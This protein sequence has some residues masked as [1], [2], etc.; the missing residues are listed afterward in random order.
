MASTA[1]THDDHAGGH[2]H[3]KPNHPY[4]LVDPS[5]WPLVGSLSALLLTGGGV[6][7]MHGV[8][9]G[10][11]VTLLGFAGV[12]AV[13]V[14]WW[15]DVLRELAS[16]AHSDVVSKG[17]RLGMALFIVSEVFFF[18][19]FFWA[20]FWGALNP[21]MTVATQWP[22]EGVEPVPAWGIPFLNTLILLLSGAAVTWAHHAVRENDQQGPR[23][24]PLLITVGLGVVFTGFQVLEYVEQIHAGFTL[25]GARSGRSAPPSTWRP[26]S[27]ASTSMIGTIFLAVSDARLVRH[28]PAEQARRLRGRRLV[29]A[30]RRRGLAVPVRLGLLVG[31]QP[32][33]RD[34]PGR[35]RRLSAEATAPHPSPLAAGLTGRCPHCGRGRLFRG[36]LAVA[37]R[38]GACGLDLSGRTS[39]DGP[40]RSSSCWSGSW[41]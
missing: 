25:R 18:F 24:R 27:T 2:G 10:P 1:A 16:G 19:A 37:P 31:R 11:W 17:L 21:P 22:P 13:M 35:R 9:A 36:F 6:M 15:R 7:W 34:H 4:H 14:G 40:V 39:G 33:V 20:F 3:G 41:W 30:L 8:A 32:A 23:S 38:C 29:L 26:A 28:V 12:I 5:P